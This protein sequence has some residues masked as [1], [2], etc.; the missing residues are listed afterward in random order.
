MPWVLKEETDKFRKTKDRDLWEE[1]R[2]A[3][4]DD[5]TATYRD[6]WEEKIVKLRW[7]STY[8]C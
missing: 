7:N 5:K 8:I 1:E 6:L 2:Q 4:K 3:K